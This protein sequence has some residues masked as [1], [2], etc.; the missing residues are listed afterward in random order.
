MLHLLDGRFTKAKYTSIA[1]KAAFEVYS[2]RCKDYY[3]WG[4]SIVSP[5][6]VDVVGK[7]IHEGITSPC[8]HKKTNTMI[9]CCHQMSNA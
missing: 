9:P 1:T 8:R 3:G 2:E 5:Y 4:E 6:P 7:T